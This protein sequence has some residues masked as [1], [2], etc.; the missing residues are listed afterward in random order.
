MIDSEKIDSTAIRFCI[1]DGE[2]EIG[3]AFLY[4]IK[5]DLNDRPYGL[6]EDLYVNEDYRGQGNAKKLIKQVL[7][8]AQEN[9]CYKIIATSRYARPKVHE[10]Y[11]KY[12]F[13]D[14]GKEFRLDFGE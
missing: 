7:D 13:V 10:M 1:R 8:S 9:N 5:N 6:L 12:G 11:Q 4:L 14:H 2:V 3:R